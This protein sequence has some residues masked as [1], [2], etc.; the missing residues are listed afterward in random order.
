MVGHGRVNPT[1]TRTSSDGTVVSVAL[2]NIKE[3]D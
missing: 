3:A 1:D 2:A